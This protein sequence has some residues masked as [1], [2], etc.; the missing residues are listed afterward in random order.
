V[1]HSQHVCNGQDPSG[2]DARTV[3]RAVD[4]D[5]SCHGQPTVAGIPPAAPSLH[6]S[7]NPDT[8]IDEG[9]HLR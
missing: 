8:R 7:D 1:K 4:A 3:V 5:H 6:M 9:I 2:A